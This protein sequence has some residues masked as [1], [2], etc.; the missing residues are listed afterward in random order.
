MNFTK[1]YKYLN[2]ISSKNIT[3]LKRIRQELKRDISDDDRK[4]K[5]ELIDIMIE[6]KETLMR[7]AKRL[8]ELN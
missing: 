4:T 5:L 3:K 8:W 1:Q 7:G 6:G 2:F